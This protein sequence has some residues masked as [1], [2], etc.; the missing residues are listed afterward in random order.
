MAPKKNKASKKHSDS[1]AVSTAFTF[2]ATPSP[3]AVRVKGCDKLHY[4]L[5]AN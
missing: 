1:K 2:A 5:R 4:L 3:C